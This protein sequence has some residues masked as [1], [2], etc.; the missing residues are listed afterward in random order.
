M[1]VG[2]GGAVGVGVA[3]AVGV[4][5]GVGIGTGVGVG[6]EVGVGIGVGGRVGHTLGAGEGVAAGLGAGVGGEYG[7]ELDGVRVGASAWPPW[8]G[9]VSTFGAAL[10]V[11]ALLCPR[12]SNPDWGASTANNQASTNT[13]KPLTVRRNLDPSSAPQFTVYADVR[14]LVTRHI[15]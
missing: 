8:V 15:G 11:P 12:A 2:V 10:S 1:A 5:V 7:R 4:S 6:T 3:V 9:S 13:S 14:Q